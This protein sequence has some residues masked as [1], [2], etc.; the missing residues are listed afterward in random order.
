MPRLDTSSGETPAM[1]IADG[2]AIASPPGSFKKHLELFLVTIH[3]YVHTWSHYRCRGRLWGGHATHPGYGQTNGLCLSNRGIVSGWI[4]L[5][6]INVL[7]ESCEQTPSL[8]PN[9]IIIVLGLRFKW[10]KVRELILSDSLVWTAASITWKLNTILVKFHATE[11]D[12]THQKLV[13]GNRPLHFPRS[14]SPEPVQP[15][16]RYPSSRNRSF[17]HLQR[18]V[19]SP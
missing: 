15:V 5:N 8:L 14:S 4:Y 18:F 10:R 2:R 17:S 6:W 7:I 1:A 12:P 3:M 9:G 13:F 11:E 16:P 19:H